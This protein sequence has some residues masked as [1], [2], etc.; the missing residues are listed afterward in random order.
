MQTLPA[1]RKARVVTCG[2][3]LALQGLDGYSSPPVPR[4]FLG[5]LTSGVHTMPL[6]GD[7]VLIVQEADSH[8]CALIA[9][10]DTPA[11]LPVLGNGET[12]ILHP[13][14]AFIKIANP[15]GAIT[16][17]VSAGLRLVLDPATNRISLTATNGLWVN[18]TQ[19][20]VP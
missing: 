9:Q 16:L 12:L 11:S 15:S 20:T 7:S 13:S 8:A 5:G 2:Q 18:G 4:P 6:P 17:Q 10:T 1:A 14:G 3:T 19:V